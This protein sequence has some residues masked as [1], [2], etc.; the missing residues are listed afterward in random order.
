[1]NGVGKHIRCKFQGLSQL[2]LLWCVS[3]EPATC[4]LKHRRWSLCSCSIAQI[5][6]YRLKK[7]CRSAPGTRR[8]CLA[9]KRFCNRITAAIPTLVAFYLKIDVLLCFV[10]PGG[11][12]RYYYIR[13]RVNRERVFEASST[14]MTR[15][16]AERVFANG[17]LVRSEGGSINC[18]G[19]LPRRR[20]TMC[21]VR[22]PSLLW[23]PSRFVF[24]YNIIV[25]VK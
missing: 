17:F 4:L 7:Y 12:F 20:S 2:L 8:P 14:L 18:P 1:M 19:T 22:F 25:Y 9:E 15:A 6:Q 21:S 23:A 11:I 3:Y 13:G 10:R 24:E 5:F 16:V